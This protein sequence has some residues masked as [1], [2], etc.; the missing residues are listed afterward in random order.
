VEKI[1]QSP[2][3]IC[4]LAKALCQSGKGMQLWMNS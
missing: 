1:I 4:Q 3:A 2:S